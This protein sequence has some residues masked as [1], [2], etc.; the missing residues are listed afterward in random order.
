MRSYVDNQDV[1]AS[2]R[3]PSRIVSSYFGDVKPCPTSMIWI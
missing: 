2:I 1:G 3:F